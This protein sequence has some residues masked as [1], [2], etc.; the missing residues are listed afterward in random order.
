[1][2]GSR[3]GAFSLLMGDHKQHPDS[4]DFPFSYLIGDPTGNT[5]VVPGAMLRS[6]GI[7]RDDTKWKN[8]DR[9]KK[10]NLT[11]LNDRIDSDIFNPYTISMMADA[12]DTAEKRLTRTARKNR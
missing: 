10:L 9:R 2:H 12:I 6:C 4:S 11:K 3:I 7:V 8:R 1:M 5:A